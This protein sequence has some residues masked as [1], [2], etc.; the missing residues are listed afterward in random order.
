MWVFDADDRRYLDGTASPLVR[1]P[2]PRPRARSPTRVAAQMR[3]LEAYSTFG[4]FGNRPANELCE[5]ARRARADGRRADLPDLRRRRLDR[6]GGQDRPPP[7]H[8]AGPARAR[9][10]DLSRT[11]GYHG[12]HGFG[13]SHRR[14]RG[15][16]EQLGPA[17]PGTSR[18]CR[19]TRCP[20]WR[21]R[22]E[23]VG[24][25]RVAAFFCEPVIGAGGVLPAARGLHR[26]RRRPLRRA[27]HPARD[28]QRHLRLRP[29]RHLVRDRALGGR[30][31]RHD[32]VRQGRHRAATCRSAAWSSPTR[33]PAPFFEAPGGPMLRH[34]ATYAG[35][36][37]C[38][39]AALAVIDIYERDG[40]IARGARARGPAR[41]TRSRRSPTIPRSPRCAP[42]SACS[43]RSS[44]ARGARARP[45]R[46]GQGRRRARAT[47]ACSC[48]RCS[49]AVAM[50]PPL[51]VEQ[52]HID[53]LAEAIGRGLDSL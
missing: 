47:P 46:G 38:C 3:T 33:S 7:L 10:P 26:G 14:D 18:P 44:S 19:T 23:R 48:G 21:R 17:G 4:D 32:H 16:H 50:S 5:R 25:D 27:R 20:R 35:H 37:A 53:L 41:A 49:G 8:P 40:L 30:P 29:A 43:P 51:T 34:G 24:P 2:R 11:Q 52:E 39:A 15:Q 45:R 42:G 31:A 1:E 6:H 22:S 9:A 12:T 28:R 13:T 36:P